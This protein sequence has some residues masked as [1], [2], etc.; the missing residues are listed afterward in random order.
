LHEGESKRVRCRVGV[1]ELETSSKERKWRILTPI[2]EAVV[3]LLIRPVA[4]AFFLKHDRG[5]AFGAAIC[6]VV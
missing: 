2:D 3:I 1:A 5:Y 6:I 4:I